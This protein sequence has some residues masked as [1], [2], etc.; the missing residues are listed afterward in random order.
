MFKR[1][2]EFL[3]GSKPVQDVSISQTVQT[4]A[5]DDEY[6]LTKKQT[7]YALKLIKRLEG[8]YELAV[9]P[10]ELKVKDLNRLIAHNRFKNKGTLVN[11]AKKGVLRKAQ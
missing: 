6:S 8:E 1:L 3:F 7:E 9:D 5:S 2:L 11:L 10:S 4:V